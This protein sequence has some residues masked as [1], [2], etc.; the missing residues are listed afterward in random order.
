MD[1]LLFGV[2]P[3]IVTMLV[4]SFAAW[5][6]PRVHILVGA[7]LGLLMGVVNMW[8][9]VLG[10]MIA[11]KLDPMGEELA[12]AIIGSTVAILL[13]SCIPI[14]GMWAFGRLRQSNGTVRQ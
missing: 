5:L 2:W 3:M 12:S 1:L 9:G 7:A 6:L 11:V 4:C 14:A 10:I 8:V 13:G